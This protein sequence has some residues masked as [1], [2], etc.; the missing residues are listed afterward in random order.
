MD[1]VHCRI[2]ELIHPTLAKNTKLY[3]HK[4]H[5]AGLDYELALSIR[6]SRLVWINGPFDASVHDDTVFRQQLKHRTPLGK[7]GIADQ[8][9]RGEKSILCTP[10]P[11]DTHELRKFKVSLL[12]MLFFVLF[13]R[14]FHCCSSLIL[15]LFKN[16]LGCVFDMKHLTQG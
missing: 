8:V 12:T 10:N 2:C 5:Q 16:R 7:N 3:S 14:L 15:W 6:E 11:H 1:G 13:G 9:Y 4:F